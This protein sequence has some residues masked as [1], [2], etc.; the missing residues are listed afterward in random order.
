MIRKSV[1]SSVLVVSDYP[2][3][4]VGS[5]C[6]LQA[7]YV[8]AEDLVL[9]TIDE[10]RTGRQEEREW[11]NGEFTSRDTVSPSRIRHISL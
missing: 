2:G 11:L 1:H 3:C 4:T 7:V 8:N 5:L 6:S 10:T 9:S